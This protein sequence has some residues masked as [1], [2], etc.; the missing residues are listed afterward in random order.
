MIVLAE[1]ILLPFLPAWLWGLGIGSNV[2]SDGG[3]LFVGSLLGDIPQGEVL[4]ERVLG[5]GEVGVVNVGIHE[6]VD[7]VVVGAVLVGP[8]HCREEQG[9]PE[10]LV[11]TSPPDTEDTGG[12][13]GANNPGPLV[14]PP[15]PDLAQLHPAHPAD[16]AQ[17]EGD[18]VEGVPRYLGLPLLDL[19]NMSARGKFS[20]SQSSTVSR[21]GLPYVNEGRQGGEE[22]TVFASIE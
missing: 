10:S 2:R 5:V 21:S 7:V 12:H 17:G 19:G 15:Q 11:R 13:D 16:G 14:L 8:A 18:G 3:V 20:L 1:E 9:S 22:E 4:G 6:G